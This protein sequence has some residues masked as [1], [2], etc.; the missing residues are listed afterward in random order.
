MEKKLNMRSVLQWSEKLPGNNLNNKNDL[1]MV[2]NGLE[3]LSLR[4][5]LVLKMVLRIILKSFWKCNLETVISK[6]K[7]DL[8]TV[9][10]IVLK[11]WS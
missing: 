3:K 2:K 4:N 5:G 10:K 6:M 11:H 8:K 9:L 7:K 1:K